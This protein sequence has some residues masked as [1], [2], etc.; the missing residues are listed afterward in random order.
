MGDNV[1]PVAVLSRLRSS[2][3]VKESNPRSWNAL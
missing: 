3:A 1:S 2:T